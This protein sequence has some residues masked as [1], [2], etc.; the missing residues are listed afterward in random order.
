LVHRPK[1]N[2]LWFH[3]PKLQTLVPQT[4]TKCPVF[5]DL[6]SGYNK[7]LPSI[8]NET[9]KNRLVLNTKIF[10]YHYK[11][12]QI[13][14]CENDIYEYRNVAKNIFK[15]TRSSSFNS[16]FLYSQNFLLKK[17]FDTVFGGRGQF[18]GVK[19]LKSG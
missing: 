4:Q 16:I 3:R 18:F 5:F 13:H 11:Y 14:A 17:F 6:T 10:F 12:I 7:K 9:T 8:L 19:S 15:K 1:P 2:A